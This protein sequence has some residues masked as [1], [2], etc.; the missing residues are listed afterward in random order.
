MATTLSFLRTAAKQRADMVNSSF[1]S[2]AEWN[3]NINASYQ[4]LYDILA[5]KYGNDYFYKTQTITTDGIA[6]NFALPADFFKLLGV[7]LQ[8]T[9]GNAPQQVALRPFTFQERNRYSLPNFQTW[10]GITNLRY[11]LRAQTIWFI[12]LP[13][14]NL[15]IILLYVPILT[16]LVNDTD[17]MSAAT[18]GM[19]WEEYVIVDAAIKALQ[20]EESD[21]SALAVRKEALI[22]RIESAAEN[23]DAGM[24]A[25]VTDTQWSNSGW[26][27]AAGYSGGGA[28]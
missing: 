16:T 2:D 26:P 11:R 3:N 28:I 9:G 19:G 25:T 12:P 13:A 21:I 23:R 22:R 1:L 24:P 4:E 8:I 6:N 18:D 14:A 15:T 5:Q 7:D 20:K 17:V 27:G 10:V